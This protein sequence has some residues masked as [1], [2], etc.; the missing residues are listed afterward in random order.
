MVSYIQE[1]QTLKNKFNLDHDEIILDETLITI[2][3]FTFETNAAIPATGT[4]SEDNFIAENNRFRYP[5]ITPVKHSKDVIILL[6]GLNERTWH[7]H[8][9]GARFLAEKSGRPV[10]LFPLSF[11]INRGLPE[12]IDPR[13]M[14]GALEERKKKYPGIR[15][16][17]VVNLALSERLTECPERFFHSGLQSAMDLIKLMNEIRAGEH[18]LFE[19]G[20]RISI[21]AYSISCMMLQSLIISNPGNVLKDT[22]IVLFAGGSVF[23]QVQGIS[24]FIMDSVAFETIKKYYTQIVIRKNSFLNNLQPGIIEQSY[25]NAFRAIVLPDFLRRIRMKAFKEFSDRILILALRE[26]KI[27]PINGIREAFGPRFLKSRN[28]K[29][30]HFPYAYSHENPF[31]VLYE[32]LDKLV[33][34]GFRSVYEPALQFL[35]D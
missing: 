35:S 20:T 21:F 12:W 11:H 3:N 10:L 28:S 13:K 5:V 33:G 31:P 7:K 24:R 9:T 22:K 16:A 34:E 17:S 15:E 2:R 4:E 25:G 29:I 6:H 19:K 18:P 1:Y 8:L 26:D 27:M 30:I 23:S 14:A 32:Q